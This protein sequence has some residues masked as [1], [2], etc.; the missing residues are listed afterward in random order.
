MNAPGFARAAP[1][2][3]TAMAGDEATLLIW[4]TIDSSRF[5]SRGRRSRATTQAISSAPATMSTTH[6][7]VFGL[8]ACSDAAASPS[9]NAAA[10]PTPSVAVSA[11]R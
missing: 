1:A 4:A 5:G 3:T 2:P 11:P 9:T 10:I 6:T 8:D 7:H